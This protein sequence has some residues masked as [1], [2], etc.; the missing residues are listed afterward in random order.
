MAKY[1]AQTHM[2]MGLDHQDSASFKSMFPF[3]RF[4][5]GYPLLTHRPTWLCVNL[6]CNIVEFAR[7]QWSMDPTWRGACGNTCSTWCKGTWHH[8]SSGRSVFANLKVLH[9]PFSL[10]SISF[11]YYYYYYYDY[12][13][14]KYTNKKTKTKTKTINLLIIISYFL[15]KGR[16]CLCSSSLQ[17][18]ALEALHLFSFFSRS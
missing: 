9:F 5:F 16:G 8:G 6:G 11:L 14:N 15:L 10:A 17:P 3:T 18:S 12:Y 2:V 7:R 13:Y 4:R 1:T